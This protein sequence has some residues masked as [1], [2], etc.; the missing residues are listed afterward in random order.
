M[1]I[2]QVASAYLGYFEVGFIICVS[3]ITARL[4]E[5]NQVRKRS[6]RECF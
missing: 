5:V 4:L 3:L 2:F 1:T 6:E